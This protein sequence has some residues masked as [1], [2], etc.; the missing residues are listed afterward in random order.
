MEDTEYRTQPIRGRAEISPMLGVDVTPG[1][2]SPS[3]MSLS[4]GLFLEAAVRG[5]SVDP[6]TSK[7]LGLLPLVTAYCSSSRT[8]GHLKEVGPIPWVVPGL[9][10]ADSEPPEWVKT[11]GRMAQGTSGCGVGVSESQCCAWS[12]RENSRCSTA[13]GLCLQDVQG[14]TRLL[15]IANHGE[16]EPGR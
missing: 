1:K 6:V 2:L 13:P 15:R 3:G 14:S 8:P 4:P 12:V 10:D 5:S 16:M 11:P 9:G 7:V